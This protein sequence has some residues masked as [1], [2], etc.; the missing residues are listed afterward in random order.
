MIR[1]LGTL[2]DGNINYPAIYG[3]AQALL[4]IEDARIER[5]EPWVLGLAA[6]L[7]TGLRSQGYDLLTSDVDGHNSFI[8][9][10]QHPQAFALRKFVYMEGVVANPLDTT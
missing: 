9:C 6:R 2:E 8:V 7:D 1:R 10:P 4:M 3:L 5:L